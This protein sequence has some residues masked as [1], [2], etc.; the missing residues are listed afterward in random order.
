MYALCW[1]VDCALDRSALGKVSEAQASG[2]VGVYSKYLMIL[3]A[4]VDKDEVFAW[5][6]PFLNPL[7]KL[8][9]C[10]DLGLEIR[11][12]RI[13]LEPRSLHFRLLEGHG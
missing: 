2:L 5:L 7:A 8:V 11:W 1:E 6:L 13:S 3:A 12:W 9:P 4:D 10:H